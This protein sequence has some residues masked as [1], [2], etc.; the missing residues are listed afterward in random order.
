MEYNDRVVA[1]STRLM[2]SKLGEIHNTRFSFKKLL[3]RRVKDRRGNGSIRSLTIMFLCLRDATYVVWCIYLDIKRGAPIISAM[4]E[5]EVEVKTPEPDAE[6]SEGPSCP[7]E[8]P[9]ENLIPVF[10]YGKR[11]F[12]PESFTIITAMEYVGFQFKKAIGCREGFCGACATIY[13][14]EGDY[15]LRTGLAC[16]TVVELNMHLVQLPFT[17]AVKAIYDIEKLKPDISA[18]QRYYPEVF[19]CVACNTCTKA[20]PQEIEVMDYIQAVKRG[21]LECAADLSFDCIM[22]G[23]CAVRCPAEMV[24]YNIALLVR[25]LTGRYLLPRSAHLAERLAEQKEGRYEKEI[26][27]LKSLPGKAL[28]K[29]YTERDLDFKVF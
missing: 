8:S 29:R 16:Q 24:Q 12:V 1:T 13:R 4:D 15:K 19:R 10:I 22:C 5:K 7:D 17:P 2:H 3:L 18:V 27:E 11:F 14:L 26:E 23:L 9:K 21:D 6:S 20:C 28:A 25:R